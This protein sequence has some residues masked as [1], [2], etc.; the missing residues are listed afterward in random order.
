MYHTVTHNFGLGH[1]MIFNNKTVGIL[2]QQSKRPLQGNGMAALSKKKT[3]Q[4]NHCKIKNKTVFYVCTRMLV[5]GFIT[6]KNS[7]WSAQHP[8]A[9]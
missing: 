4:E 9:G 5:K 6:R 2:S 3:K 1:F 7:V 8:N